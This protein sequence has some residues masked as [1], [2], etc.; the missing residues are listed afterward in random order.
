MKNKKKKLIFFNAKQTSWGTLTQ[1][2]WG[3]LTTGQHI[4]KKCK[5]EPNGKRGGR[6]GVGNKDNT[7]EC[8]HVHMDTEGYHSMKLLSFCSMDWKA[9]WIEASDQF[10]VI[11]H[12]EGKILQRD[13]CA[14]N[15]K[16]NEKLWWSRTCLRGT[17]HIM[18]KKPCKPRVLRILDRV[19]LAFHHVQI[20]ID[21]AD[22]R[23]MPV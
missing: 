23:F 16:L 20:K 2:A 18:R 22:S 5:A 11:D 10:E 12:S 21:S 7:C 13:K 4:A 14:L 1:Y 15:Y 9:T 3:I 8:K 6:E 19:L 17:S